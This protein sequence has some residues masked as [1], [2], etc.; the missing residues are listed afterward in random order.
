MSLDEVR[1]GDHVR[2]LFSDRAT[3]RD[4]DVVRVWSAPV[5]PGAGCVNL[6]VRLLGTDE[7]GDGGGE[8]L[9]DEVAAGAAVRTSVTYDPHARRP[10]SWRWSEDE[11]VVETRRA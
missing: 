3:V 4:A 8:I 5:Y 1:T 2:Y 10:C 9:A 6:R 11:V 7:R